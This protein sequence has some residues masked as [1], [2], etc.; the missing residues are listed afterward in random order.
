MAWFVPA[1]EVL[2]IAGMVSTGRWRGRPANHAQAEA[3][4]RE[5]AAIQDA[6]PYMEPPYWYYPVRQTLAAVLLEAGRPAEAAAA[7]SRQACTT[8]PTTPSPSTA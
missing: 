1:K 2:T 4:L 5:A 6:L 3:A 8:R 7:S